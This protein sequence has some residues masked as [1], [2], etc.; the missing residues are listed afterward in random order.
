ML[1]E[2][3]HAADPSIDLTVPALEFEPP[4]TDFIRQN[5]AARIG[6][7]IITLDG[8]QDEVTETSFCAREHAP[9]GGVIADG[10][11]LR[12]IGREEFL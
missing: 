1:R 7:G 3:V 9:L 5:P 4:G 2:E 8:R 12:E 10:D 6:R 11:D